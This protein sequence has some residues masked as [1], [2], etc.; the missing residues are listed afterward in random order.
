LARVRE[1]TLEAYA[2]QSYPFDELVDELGLRR[3]TSR[4]PLFDVLINVPPVGING[5]IPKFSNI[6]VSPY[7]NR[8]P[9]TSKFDL[10][11]IFLEM[12]EDLRIGIEYN[13]DIYDKFTIERMGDHLE[14][15]LESIVKDPD[16]AIGE[17]EYLSAAEQYQ[18]L[19]TFN[20]TYTSKADM[21]K[22][23]G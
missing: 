23:V 17:L 10:T 21:G 13:R 6:L 7:V 4:S 15:L 19:V 22:K 11:F 3:D 9:E 18:L 20:A 8:E 1:T 16:I 2:H 12:G 14:G 5:S